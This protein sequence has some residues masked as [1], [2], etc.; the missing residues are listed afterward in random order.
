MAN[1]LIDLQHSAVF[2]AGNTFNSA[3]S[4][5][6]GLTSVDCSNAAADRMS[7]Y[8]TTTA[9]SGAGTVVIQVQES[10]DNTNWTSVNGGGLFTVL[11]AANQSQVVSWDPTAHYVRGYATLTG[12]SVTLQLTFIYLPKVTPVGVAG[13]WVNEQYPNP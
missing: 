3:V 8:V 13:G 2:V 9:V 12:T 10:V 1:T 5:T 4:I 11:N 6:G 7:A